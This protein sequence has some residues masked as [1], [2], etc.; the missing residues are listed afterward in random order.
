M[1]GEMVQALSEFGASRHGRFDRAAGRAVAMSAA[2]E[3]GFLRRLSILLGVS[4]GYHKAPQPSQPTSLTLVPRRLAVALG[5]LAMLF[6]AMAP[7]ASLAASYDPASDVYSMDNTTAFTGAAT[8]WNAGYTGAGVDVALIDTG[9]SPVEGLTTPGKIVYG[10]DL[11]LESQA[12]NLRNLDTMGHGTFMAGLIAGRD[13]TVSAPFADAPAS[14]YRGMAPDARIVSLKVGVAD[15][16]VDVSQVVAAVD[17]VVQH[18]NDNGMHIRVINLS[19]GTN[20]TQASTVDPL[21]YAVEQAW[22]KGIVVVVAGGNA[23]FQSHMNAAPALANPANDRYVLAVG[24]TDTLGTAALSDDTV[25]AFSPWPKRGATR[26]VDLVAPGVHMQG[27]RDPNSYID[28]AQPEGLLGDRYFRGSGT[29]QSAAIVSGAAALVLQ[30][31]PDAT[32]DQVKK[33]LTSTGYQINAKAQAI[34]G[35]ELQLAKALVTT[36]PTS[37]QTWPFAVG[38]GSL[39]RARGSDHLTIEGVV[40]SGEIDIF[41]HSFDSAAMAALEAAEISWSGGTWNGNSWSGNSWSGN[42]WSGNS[43]SGNSWSGNSWSGNSWSGNSWSGNSWSGNS[44]SGNSW[45]GNSWSG[46][47]WSGH[48]WY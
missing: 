35:G 10:P 38:T 40:L 1:K 33:L 3:K 26:G 43:W 5:S 14:A 20:S 18:C 44:W 34:G 41:G 42:S 9:V 22:R 7:A 17:W 45:S 28:V 46:N 48:A 32:P 24:S 25:P 47:S 31:Y 6:S 30:K 8:W 11:S 27:L 21:A 37:V 4:W 23:G 39:E 29:S 2:A 15:G 12:E 36:L 19:Y 13:S 16:G